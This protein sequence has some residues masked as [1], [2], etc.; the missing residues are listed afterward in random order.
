M[1]LTPR[2]QDV[3][4]KMREED[5]SLSSYFGS[6]GAFH[7]VCW[8]R[9]D[10]GKLDT[11]AIEE[12]DIDTLK[13]LGLI[14]V[15]FDSKERF[16]RHYRLIPDQVAIENLKLKAEARGYKL[17]RRLTPAGIEAAKEQ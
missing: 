7:D 12:S 8:F 15:S 16:E 13:A 11:I 14:E 5:S 2:Q 6:D 3:I 9:G 4:D 10:D 1:N 17:A